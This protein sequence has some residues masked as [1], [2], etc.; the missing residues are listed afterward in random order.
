MEQLFQHSITHSNLLNNSICVLSQSSEINQS[1]V[2]GPV[3][4]ANVCVEIKR[5]EGL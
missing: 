1:K 3:E 4:I 5:H 2:I